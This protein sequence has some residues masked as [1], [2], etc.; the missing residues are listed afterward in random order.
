[1]LTFLTAAAFVGKVRRAEPLAR[2]PGVPKMLTGFRYEDVG[3]TKLLLLLTLEPGGLLGAT[4][5][6]ADVC[7]TTLGSVEGMGLPS[8][9]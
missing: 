4:V 7:V 5:V 1:M 9:V 6:A 3:V 2:A 8:F